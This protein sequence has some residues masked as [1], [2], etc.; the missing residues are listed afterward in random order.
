[1]NLMS[2]IDLYLIEEVYLA[3]LF[4]IHYVNTRDWSWTVFNDVCNKLVSVHISVTSNV[5]AVT[6]ENYEW[7]IFPILPVLKAAFRLVQ[8]Y[9]ALA[10]FHQQIHAQISFT[11]GHLHISFLCK[12]SEHRYQMGYFLQKELNT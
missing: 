2:C 6:D 3:K 4:S 11:H 5:L 7:C 10:R 9:W 8:N 12:S 1:M